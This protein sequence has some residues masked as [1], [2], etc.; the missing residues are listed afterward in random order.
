ML[1]YRFLWILYAPGVLSLSGR[2]MH[3]GRGSP[4]VWYFPEGL[5]EISCIGNIVFSRSPTGSV[6]MRERPSASVPATAVRCEE[7]RR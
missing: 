3:S 4:S 5:P 1:V 2:L 7:S 6:A